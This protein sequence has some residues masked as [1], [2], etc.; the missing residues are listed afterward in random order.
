MDRGHENMDLAYE[1]L[2]LPTPKKLVGKV[3][4]S[5]ARS[6]IFV[7]KVHFVVGKGPKI[8]GQGL[9][10]LYQAWACRPQ[11][12]RFRVSELQAWVFFRPQGVSGFRAS[13]PG[14]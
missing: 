6:F 7:G 8:R 9:C 14:V 1:Y 10:F 11:G 12:L 13:R 3:L 2:G 4:F 5:W